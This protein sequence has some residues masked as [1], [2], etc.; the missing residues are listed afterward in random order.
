MILNKTKM[1]K[2][3]V[4]SLLL[5]LNNGVL[6]DSYF[7]LSRGNSKFD[8][9]GYDAASSYKIYAGARNK[10]M[11]LEWAY[12]NLGDFKVSG[13]PFIKVEGS[14]IEFSAIGFVPM[15]EKIELFGKFGFSTWAVTGVILGTDITSETGTTVSYGAGLQMNLVDNFA[16]RAEYQNFND[17]SSATVTSILFGIIYSY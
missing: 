9:D 1:K 7:G 8:F 14:V 6:A 5:V 2:T 15:S 12:I 4:L 16:L 17:V 10:N 11:G 13:A 3:L